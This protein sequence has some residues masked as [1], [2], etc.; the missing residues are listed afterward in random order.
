[1][2]WVKVICQK[3]PAEEVSLQRVTCLRSKNN[4]DTKP[5]KCFDSRCVIKKFDQVNVYWIIFN[6]TKK[7]DLHI[8]MVTRY[9]NPLLDL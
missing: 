4:V 1:M 7:F 2:P 5:L 6:N 3:S 8:L 9:L